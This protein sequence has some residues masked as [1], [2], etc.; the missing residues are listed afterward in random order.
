[1]LNM[2]S[3]LVEF[4]QTKSATIHISHNTLKKNLRYSN[5]KIFG[6]NLFETTQIFFFQIPSYIKRVMTK[7]EHRLQLKHNGTFCFNKQTTY[8]LDKTRSMPE[9]TTHIKD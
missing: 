8:C 3:T 5:L 1:M 9:A 6:K 4:H 7:V 2:P